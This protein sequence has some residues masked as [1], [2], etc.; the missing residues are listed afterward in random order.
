MYRRVW[1][2][3]MIVEEFDVRQER[4]LNNVMEAIRSYYRFQYGKRPAWSHPL[5]LSRLSRLCKKSN[6]V[7]LAAVR[8]L[9]NT[10]GPNGEE[11]QIFYDRISAEKNACHRPYRIF[12]REEARS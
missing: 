2:G 3:S 4:L 5:S 12:L 10:R 8:V 11:P 7:V 9:A 6:V 1:V